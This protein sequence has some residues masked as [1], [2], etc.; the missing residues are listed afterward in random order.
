M[1]IPESAGGE[2]FSVAIHLPSICTNNVVSVA[3][4]ARVRPSKRLTWPFIT[5][6]VYC[7]T[8]VAQ[9]TPKTEE[10]QKV[11]ESAAAAKKVGTQLKGGTHDF[12]SYV[13]GVVLSTRYTATLEG[14][15]IRKTA[16]LEPCYV[17]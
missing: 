11:A 14:N 1:A 17:R 2:V 7:F 5:S 10:E 4:R 13:H 3:V 8:F 16:R 15:Y 12:Y 9:G 6:R